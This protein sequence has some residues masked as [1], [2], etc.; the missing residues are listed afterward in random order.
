MFVVKKVDQ[1]KAHQDSISCMNFANKTLYTGSFDSKIHMWNVVELLR[2]V[3]NRELMLVEDGW[4]M[5]FNIW[6]DLTHK[7]KKGRR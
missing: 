3:K 6:Y 5:K 1:F 2:K 7:K 4:S